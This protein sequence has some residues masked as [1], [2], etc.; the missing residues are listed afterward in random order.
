M[1]LASADEAEH[2]F[3]LVNSSNYKKGPVIHFR[4]QGL[5][6]LINHA[7][8]K[9]SVSAPISSRASVYT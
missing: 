8:M 3:R 2:G 6:R 9:L 7:K 1:A 5:F 4:A